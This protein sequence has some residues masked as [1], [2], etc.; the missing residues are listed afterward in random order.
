MLV[1]VYKLASCNYV[2]TL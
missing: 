1:R 2:N